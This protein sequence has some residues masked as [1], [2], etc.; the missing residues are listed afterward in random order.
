MD[1]VEI[2]D[3]LIISTTMI[4]ILGVLV[5]TL[6]NF[7]LDS[8][9]N[10]FRLVPAK[11]SVFDTVLKSI[12]YGTLMIEIIIM[13]GML[14]SYIMNGPKKSENN[15]YFPESYA[16]VIAIIILVLFLILIISTIKIFFD[17]KDKVINMIQNNSEGKKQH[18][19]FDGYK[20]KKIMSN[21]IIRKIN[22]INK[23]IALFFTGGSAIIL[24]A[25]V[26]SGIEEKEINSL[27]TLIFIGVVGLSM[28][29]LSN[30]VSPAIDM[31]KNKS[32]YYLIT[33]SNVIICSFFFEYQ[34]YY[35][36]IEN[37]VE[38]YIKKAEVTEI[39]KKN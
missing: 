16:Q 36:L 2:R 32:I 23:I 21:K 15:S 18:K 34:E 39:K 5:K 35:L 20:T 8:L 13:F 17:V 24:L 19:K 11:Q 7:F 4:T 14:I 12:S 38:R 1:R 6:N 3:L 27:I 22:S 29:I 33:K 9:K 28:F 37:E 25:N 26:I 10:L 30:S 31:L